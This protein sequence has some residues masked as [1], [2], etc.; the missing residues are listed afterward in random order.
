[1]KGLNDLPRAVLQ[2]V[3]GS[4]ERQQE[5]RAIQIGKFRQARIFVKLKNKYHFRRQR[6]GMN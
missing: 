3:Q 2:E 1:M 5:E 4:L 6:L